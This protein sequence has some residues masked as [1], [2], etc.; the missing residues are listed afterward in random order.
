MKHS[1][2]YMKKST[3]PKMSQPSIEHP[4]LT[5]NQFLIVFFRLSVVF[6]DMNYKGGGHLNQ[7]ANFKKLISLLT[8][9][10][11]TRGFSDFLG[12]VR[13]SKSI[14]L[15]PSLT[16]PKALLTQLYLNEKVFSL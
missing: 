10:E 1:S 9:V 14:K 3:T 12:Q 4:E 2:F 7:V 16:P 8:R 15:N 11:L 13:I 6:F 5:F